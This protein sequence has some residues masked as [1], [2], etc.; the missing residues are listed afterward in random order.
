MPKL[1]S[2]IHL[3]MF[4]Q[5]QKARK[6]GKRL[7]KAWQVL[8]GKGDLYG[9]EWGDPENIPPLQHVRDHFLRPYVTPST[10]VLE[11]GPGGGRWTR[12]LMR[13]QKIYAVDYHQPLLD[14]LA[15]NFA[16][17][18]GLVPIKNNG[19]DF[20][21]VPEA[22][23]DF[24]FSFGVFV[25]LDLDVIDAYLENLKAVLKPD[26]NVVIQYSDKTKPLAISNPGFSD[27]DPQRMQALVLKHGY[28]IHEQ[29][30]QTMWHSAIIR[31]GPAAQP[32]G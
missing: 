16:G 25:H 17:Q 26:A 31:F 8:L 20:P 3:D 29:D 12:Y 24:V 10:I 21:G 5:G 1:D 27:N 30:T 7:Q 2:P 22:S 28:A 9:L 14:E 18:D 13:A 19:T 23:V 6:L 32:A 11:I 4:R 15:S